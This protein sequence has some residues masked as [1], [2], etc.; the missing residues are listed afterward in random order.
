MP[1]NANSFIKAT[2]IC[3]KNIR[4][5]NGSVAIYGASKLGWFART[6]LRQHGLTVNYFIDKNASSTFRYFHGTPVLSTDEVIKRADSLPIIICI[7]NSEEVTVVHQNLLELGLNV[8]ET[9]PYA[10]LF[11]YFT[12]VAARRCNPD[13]LA[14]SIEH[15]RRY[16]A[17]GHYSY[18]QISEDLFVSPLVVGNVTTKCNLKCI[19]CGQSIPYYENPQSF[20]VENL[21]S[22]IQ[23]YCESVDLVPEISLHGGEPFLHPEIG[24]L[25][26]KLAEIPNLVFINL[27]TNGTVFPTPESWG[28]FQE[29]GVDIHQSDYRRIS[30]RQ[31][32]I[33]E[34]CEENKIYCDINWTNEFE[35]WWRTPPLTNYRRSK[36][37]NNRVYQT[38]VSTNICAQIIEGKLY[39]CPV[40]AHNTEK[41]PNIE[42]TDYV[43]LLNSED[44][45]SKSDRIR[46]YLTKKDCLTACGFCDPAGS[47]LVKPALQLSPRN[48]AIIEAGGEII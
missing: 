18:G 37:Q 38:C 3:V 13:R 33:F 43:N 4:K 47:K 36:K 34:L 31:A 22:E 2:Q 41:F 15:L 24:K 16:Y 9:D 5:T 12:S 35:M 25:C 29:A 19:D 40:A 44:S 42:T 11:S 20:S 7:F 6:V 23:S 39:R 32:P 27:I 10:L 21:V 17:L 48:K 28:L 26:Q 45:K 46:N 8:T 1:K 30:K 14:E